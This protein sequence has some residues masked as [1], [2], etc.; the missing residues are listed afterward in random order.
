MWNQGNLPNRKSN[1]NRYLSRGTI[2]NLTW[3]KFRRFTFEKLPDR[4]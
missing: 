1:K 3:T 4:E 2:D